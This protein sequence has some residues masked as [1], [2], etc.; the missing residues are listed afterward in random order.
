MAVSES[1]LGKE[2]IASPIVA[3]CNEGTERPS[4]LA[5]RSASMQADVASIRRARS[6]HGPALVPVG[7]AARREEARES[8]EE[9]LVVEGLEHENVGAG[10]EGLALVVPV[11][12]GGER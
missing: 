10:V 1:A 8:I 11:G 12:A 7:V 3:S 4:A 6:R 2:S 5:R 9:L